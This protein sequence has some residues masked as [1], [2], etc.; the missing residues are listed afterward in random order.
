MYQ[1]APV[2]R[3]TTGP[4]IRD[5]PQSMPLFA[6]VDYWCDRR[7]FPLRDFYGGDDQTPPTSPPACGSGSAIRGFRRWC[8]RR[9]SR[10]ACRGRI[11]GALGE[12][13]LYRVQRNHA[14]QTNR[15]TQRLSVAQLHRTFS[16]RP[17]HDALNRRPPGGERKDL[18]DALLPRRIARCEVR[19]PRHG[20]AMHLALDLRDL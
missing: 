11:G 20:I 3:H 7:E 12:A 16:E 8:Y 15:S 17:L 19:T 5:T 4:P 2:T 6:Q 18:R 14:L 10:R 1:K 9:R 13:H